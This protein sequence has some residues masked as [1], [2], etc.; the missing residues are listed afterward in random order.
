MAML[1][2]QMV[3]AIAIVIV[4]V[5]IS[6]SDSHSSNNSHQVRLQVLYHIWILCNLIDVFNPS[7]N[8]LVTWE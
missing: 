4:K 5:K 7:E 1:N 8:M 3:I 2:N 6:A